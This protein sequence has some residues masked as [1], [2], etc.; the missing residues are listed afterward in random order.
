MGAV[1]TDA[2]SNLI[3][4]TH[5]S[6]FSSYFDTQT[7]F[8]DPSISR[9]ALLLLFVERARAGVVGMPRPV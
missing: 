6:L 4:G 9:S 7:N 5:V 2:T 8:Y 1:L 3:N